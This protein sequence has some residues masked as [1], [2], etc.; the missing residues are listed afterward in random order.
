LAAQGVALARLSAKEDPLHLCNS[1]SLLGWSYREL[2][3]LDKAEAAL[4]EAVEILETQKQ[5]DSDLADSV[6]SNLAGVYWER[7]NF[8][9]AEPLYI[10]VAENAKANYGP[11]SWKYAKRLGNLDTLYDEWAQATGDLEK[12]RIAERYSTQALII[13]LAALGTRNLET[14]R[15]HYNL[16]I[17]NERLGDLLEA[18]KNAERS[19]AIMLSLGLERHPHIESVAVMLADLWLR[20]DNADKAIRLGRGNISDLVPAIVQIEREHRDWVAE[21]PETRNFG[22]PSKFS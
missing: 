1:L 6:L 2:N 7:K 15:S 10:R 20:S 14:A 4:N 9:F 13:A 21:A 5:L 12:R 3:E 11:E 18:I 17:L 8:S 22:P 19:F 16:A